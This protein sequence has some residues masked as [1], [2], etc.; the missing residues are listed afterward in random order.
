MEQEADN[1][2]LK[3]LERS[4]ALQGIQQTAATLNG[5]ALLKTLFR[6]LQV[7][8]LPPAGL[9]NEY[10]LDMLGELRSGKKFYSLVAEADPKLAARILAEIEKEN[11]D[12]MVI[13]KSNG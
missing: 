1:S 2:Q 9:K 3:A 8:E 4:R 5:Y 13:Q 12:E 7:G 11:I 10:L 6:L